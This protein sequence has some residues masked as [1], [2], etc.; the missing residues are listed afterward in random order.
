MYADD[1]LNLQHLL[2][3]IC[4]KNLGVTAVVFI[5]NYH[6]RFRKNAN[7]DGLCYVLRKGIQRKHIFLS[8]TVDKMGCC[9][10]LERSELG[11][12][13]LKLFRRKYL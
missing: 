1:P 10:E 12:E 5:S 4:S 6:S 2:Q 9:I 11:E 7:Y 13:T 3:H 8:K